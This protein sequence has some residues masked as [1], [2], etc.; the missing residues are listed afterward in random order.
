MNIVVTVI[1]VVVVPIFIYPNLFTS[2]PDY[3]RKY[4]KLGEGR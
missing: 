4:A 3:T 1:D 2:V